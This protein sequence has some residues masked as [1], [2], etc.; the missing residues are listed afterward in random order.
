MRFCVVNGYPET[1]R[2]ILTRAGACGADEL[3]V[4]VFKTLMPQARLETLHL[5]DLDVAVPDTRSM[6]G[7]DG[8]LWTGSNLTAYEDDP[9]VTRQIEFAGRLFETGRPTFG[10][11]WGAQIA[12]MA[13]GGTV[14]R[15]A[16]GREIGIARKICLTPEGRRHPMYQGKPEV[17]DAFA[18]HLDEI[19]RLPPGATVLSGN[20][21]S[22]VQALEIRHANGVFWGTQY[23]PEFDLY[24]LARLIASRQEPLMQEGFFADRGAAASTIAQM[25]ALAR[26]PSRKD[27]RWAL[28]IDE[29]V[30]DESMRCNELRN[31]LEHQVPA[32]AAS[33]PPRR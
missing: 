15:S 5:A 17:F 10:S 24:H 22:A 2:E 26:D 30:L 19:T 7:Y 12:V 27:L 11:C 33:R 13:A 9:R 23:H 6:D 31:W 14:G 4:R 28:G 25:E 18:S 1:T 16:R 8:F 32:R 3:F 21:H 29:D 20:D